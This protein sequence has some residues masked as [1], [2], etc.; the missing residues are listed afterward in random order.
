MECKLCPKKGDDVMVS[1]FLCGAALCGACFMKH[2]SRQK[3]AV[4]KQWW[5][6]EALMQAAAA[7]TDDN[8]K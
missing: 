8:K 1:C 5:F 4:C 2:Q 7:Y 3:C 6:M